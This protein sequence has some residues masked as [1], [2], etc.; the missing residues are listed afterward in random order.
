MFILFIC[1]YRMIISLF[2]FRVFVLDSYCPLLKYISFRHC[3]RKNK[4][5]INM[6]TAVR[7]RTNLMRVITQTLAVRRQQ[8]AFRVPKQNSSA[9]S[10]LTDEQRAY[11]L[12]IWPGKKIYDIDNN[13][14]HLRVRIIQQ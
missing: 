8:D 3:I 5:T 12:K 11:H 6:F 14:K 10:E 9:V 2:F 7:S 1:L 13:Q 4:K